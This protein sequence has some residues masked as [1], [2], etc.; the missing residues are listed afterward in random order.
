MP[1]EIFHGHLLDGRRTHARRS[2]E[3]WNL[4]WADDSG[5]SE[6]PILAVLLDASKGKLYVTRGLL[7]YVWETYNSGANVIKTRQEKRWLRELVGSVNLASMRSRQLHDEIVRLVFRAVVG[8]SRL[9]LTSVEAPLTGFSLGSFSYFYRPD[10]DGVQPRRILGQLIRDALVRPAEGGTPKGLNPD[11]ARLERV[12]L[13]EFVL[14][15]ARA[16]ELGDAA[17]RFSEG[18]QEIGL[19]AREIQPLVREMFNE[20]ALSPY[21]AFVDN[22][23]GFVRA[24]V[25]LGWWRESDQYVFLGWLLR[26]TGR[27]LTAYDLITFH[28]H[29]ANYPDALL[30]DAVMKEC[31]RR[32][33]RNPQSWLPAAGD[34]LGAAKRKRLNRRGLRQG[35]L[36][37]R[38]YEGLPVPASPTSP[39]ENTR[40]LPPPYEHVPDEQ[41]YTPQRR[42][43]RL[44]DGDPL[45]H[46][47]GPNGLRVLRQSVDDLHDPA[48]LSELGTALFIDRP[49]GVA[50][51]PLEPD[52]TPLLSYVAFSRSVAEK[53]FAQLARDTE[54]GLSAATVEELGLALKQL[55]DAGVPVPRDRAGPRPVVALQDALKVADDFLLLRTTA[56]TLRDLSELFDWTPLRS[57]VNLDYLFAG[58]PTLLVGGATETGDPLLRAYDA[59]FRLRMELRI[60]ME[61][62]YADRDG[63]EFPLG[64]LQPLQLWKGDGEIGIDLRGRGLS[65]RPQDRGSAE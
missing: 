13:L 2:L 55:L 5:R 34:D 43:E 62:G 36:L 46:Y 28:H 12:K 25:E 26:Q 47:L 31:L 45:P 38:F 24:L 56:A 19:D 40:I 10:A 7:C 4:Y 42:P 27:H 54:I 51:H 59:R 6:E 57:L 11:L 29:G 15:S 17:R 39:G 52:R 22:T 18:W 48:E 23:L 21:T 49:L 35:W 63:V 53:R 9:P 44:F 33:E 3:S 14:R 58:S 50:K 32:V 37:R 65:I 61:Q 1:W 20:V 16:S 64:G 30:L 41:I 60:C 8:T